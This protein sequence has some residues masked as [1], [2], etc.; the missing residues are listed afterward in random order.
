MPSSPSRSRASWRPAPRAAGVDHRVAVARCLVGQR[1][2]HAERGSGV[3]PLRHGIDQGDLD[4]GDAGEQASR[5]AADHAGADH[6][7]PVTDQRAG[8][9]QRVDGGLDGTGQDR[10]AG[11]HTVGHHEDRLHRHDVRRLVGV[12]AEDGAAE[13]PARAGLDDADGEVAVLDRAGQLALLERR[14][15]HGVLALGDPAAEHQRLGA[16][17][18]P[19]DQGPHQHLARPRL[20]HLGGPEL[21]AARRT[22]PVRPGRSRHVGSLRAAAG[23]HRR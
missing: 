12:Q 21:A 10:P 8:V 20:G 5:A 15:H 14:A 6:G 18:H 19:R 3:G 2:G 4:P 1:E 22:Q 23:R 7:H 16:A 11:G 17:A 13:Q 9:P